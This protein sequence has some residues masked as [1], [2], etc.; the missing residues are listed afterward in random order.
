MND[1]SLAQK[2]FQSSPY[3]VILISLHEKNNVICMQASQYQVLVTSPAVTPTKRV[4]CINGVW[5]WIVLSR[6][7][8][9]KTQYII[10]KT[11]VDY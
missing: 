6:L 4:F 3:F 11:I 10:Y 7:S 5:Y 9:E 2:L 1:F 8:M